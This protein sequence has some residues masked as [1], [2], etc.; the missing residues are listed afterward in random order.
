MKNIKEHSLYLLITEEYCCG[1]SAVEVARCAIAGGVDII[2]LRDKDNLRSGIADTA[3][4][5]AGLCKKNRV[6]FIINDDPILAEE[7]DADGVHLGQG[8][9]KL[10]TVAE[11]RKILGPKK[12]IGVSASS[13]EEAI[14]ANGEDADY[15]GFGPVFPT[16][17]KKGCIGT[18]DVGKILKLARKPVFFIGGIDLINIGELLA[19]GARNVAVIR[20]ISE[21]D[22]I[23]STVKNFKKKLGKTKN[24]KIT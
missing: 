6:T 8:D 3:R 7:V 24:G 2:Q 10:F 9:L 13:A 15:I 4:S 5:L 12:I 11:A 18:K 16:A 23:K 17:I 22:D 21:A 1:R 14:K 19:K 20:A